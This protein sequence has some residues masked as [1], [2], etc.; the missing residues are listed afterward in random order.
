MPLLGAKDIQ[1]AYNG[2]VILSAASL[3]IEAGEKV[4][5]VGLNGSGKTT[6]ARILAGVEEPDA[7]EVVRTRGMTLAYLSQEPVMDANSTALEVSLSGLTVW[8]AAMADYEHISSAI[9]ASTGSD[10][11]MS[12]L[13]EK[14]SEAA[15]AIEDAGGWDMSHAAET[16]LSFL[17]VVNPSQEVGTMSGGEKRRVAM[18]RVF[19]PEPD[20]VI[21]DEPTNHLDIPTIQWLE[22]FLTNQYDGALLLITHDRFLLDNVTSRTIEVENGQVYSYKGGWELYLSQKAARETLAEKVETNRQNFLRQELEWL[23]RQPK[24]RTTK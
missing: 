9:A 24:A 7:G 19:L 18:A 20:L 23:S 15:I 11:D 8:S 12:S 6:F 16:M 10:A 13:I 2:R 4:V 1:K 17:G 14:Q 3:T 22:Q 5:V 21:L